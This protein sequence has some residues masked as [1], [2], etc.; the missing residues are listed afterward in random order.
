VGDAAKQLVNI[1]VRS[2]KVIEK[3]KREE[4]REKKREE[5]VEGSKLMYL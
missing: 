1:N 4:E 3:E 5:G 2:A